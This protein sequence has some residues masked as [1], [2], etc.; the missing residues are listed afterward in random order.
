MDK[1]LMSHPE[2]DL[3]GP[4]LDE[5]RVLDLL[6]DLLPDAELEAA[7][8]HL[9]LCEPC[10][11]LLRRRGALL[12]RRR[13]SHELAAPMGSLVAPDGS[14]NQPGEA[15]TVGPRL[16][17]A[18]TASGSNW[19][20]L[21]GG[22]RWLVGTFRRPRYA[23]GLGSGLL[24]AVTLVLMTVGPQRAVRFPESAE[25]LPSAAE[26]LN[27]RNDAEQTQVRDLAVALD[28]YDRRDLPTAIQ[29][30][31]TVQASGAMETMRLVF[32]GSALTQAGEYPRA[33]PILRSVPLNRLPE[34]WRSECD[35]T[36]LVAL[37]GA[38]EAAAADSILRAL[39]DQTSVVGARARR[40]VGRPHP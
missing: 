30:L 16:T 38:G 22:C 10:E 7:G 19:E 26:R 34:P 13:A 33:V 3:V 36:L 8:R 17:A 23:L 24:V 11:D 25:W 40:L 32:L 1:P 39:A 9:A 21:F 14:T 28:A 31:S 27:L 15:Q 35:W 5:D 29:A 18:P 4:H 2:Q 6:L 20:R 12:E 37:H